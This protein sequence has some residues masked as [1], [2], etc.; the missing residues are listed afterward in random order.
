MDKLSLT[1][2]EVVEQNKSLGE[3]YGEVQPL[4][5]ET[6]VRF[7]EDLCKDIISQ[8][9]SSGLLI[10]KGSVKCEVESLYYMFLDLIAEWMKTWGPIPEEILCKIFQKYNNDE[11][12]KFLVWSKNRLL[13]VRP[14]QVTC[15][16]EGFSIEF[17]D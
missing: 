6:T 13:Y 8:F 10:D 4:V 2:K 5:T 17:N 3:F 15:S 1:V 11:T 14:C 9:Q 12:D 7:A 16:R